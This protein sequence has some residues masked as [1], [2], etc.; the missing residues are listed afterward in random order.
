MNRFERALAAIN[1]SD[2]LRQ[3]DAQVV[4]GFNRLLSIRDLIVQTYG[5]F[6]RQVYVH[7][8]GL[9]QARVQDLP[10]IK[11]HVVCSPLIDGTSPVQKMQECLEFCKAAI[12]DEFY[13]PEFTPEVVLE[14][15]PKLHVP[16][17]TLYMNEGVRYADDVILMANCIL[18]LQKY[19]VSI[20]IGL[21]WK[22]AKVKSI[23][24]HCESVA[25]VPTL[26]YDM[27]ILAQQIGTS[28]VP[29]DKVGDGVPDWVYV[30]FIGLKEI[31]YDI[32]YAYVSSFIE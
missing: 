20:P 15:G 27:D 25:D 4:A 16:Y 7:P 23:I 10:T 18:S 5:D 22:N 8:M 31:P 11:L 17:L 6:I 9:F 29:H 1:M 28:I 21:S 24:V 19:H 30:P 14:L 26:E 3:S 2:Y 12:C 13:S 32:P